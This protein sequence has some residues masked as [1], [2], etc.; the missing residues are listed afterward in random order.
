MLCDNPSNYYAEPDAMKFLSV[1][2]TVWDDT[3][4]LQAKVGNY[5]AVARQSGDEWYVGAMTNWEKRSMELKFDFLPEGDYEIT[6]WKDG[7]NA[8]RHASDYKMVTKSV[9]S[10]GVLN[11]DLAPGG[12]WAAIIT[13]K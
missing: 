6:I 11:V 10:G 9:L 5:I 2:P 12:G 7:I 13:K 8:D 4:V 3:K 1:V